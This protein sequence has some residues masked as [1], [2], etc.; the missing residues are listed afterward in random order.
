MFLGFPKGF[1]Q[2]FLARGRPNLLLKGPNPLL[3][4]LKGLATLARGRPWRQMGRSTGRPA[5]PPRSTAKA[6]VGR[7][8]SCRGGRRAGT[9]PHNMRL[10]RDYLKALYKSQ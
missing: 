1:P 3:T 4:L 8:E 9:W 2:F 6:I 10:G 5:Q 7:R